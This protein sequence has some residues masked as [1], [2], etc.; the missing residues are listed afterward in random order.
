MTAANALAAADSCPGT[1]ACSGNGNCSSISQG[2]AQCS[3]YAGWDGVD[4]SIGVTQLDPSAPATATAN[5]ALASG[6][7][8]FF[9]VNTDP[10]FGDKLSITASSSNRKPLLLLARRNGRP[11]LRDFEEMDSDSWFAGS[12]TSSLTVPAVFNAQGASWYIGVYNHPLFSGG[13]AQLTLSTAYGTSVCPI[14]ATRGEC[15][16]RGVCASDKCV[17]NDG[18]SGAGCTMLLRDNPDVDMF[19]DR[20]AFPLTDGTSNG[21]VREKKY[22]V[23]S[24]TVPAGGKVSVSVT[25]LGVG[26]VEAFA[27]VGAYPKTFTDFTIRSDSAGGA[28]ALTVSNPSDSPTSAYIGLYGQVTSE[29]NMQ[30]TGTS[31]S[32]SSINSWQIGTIVAA[33]VAFVL[34]IALV[35]VIVRKNQAKE[36]LAGQDS[37]PPVAAPAV[38]TQA[39]EWQEMFDAT[40]GRNYYYNSRTG[41]TEWNKPANAV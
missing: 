34:L 4:C 38:A 3:C 26:N 5:Q 25:P 18:W 23:Y 20:D 27:T 15:S 9:Q 35:V 36:G 7:W 28:Q 40:T 30:A 8:A 31:S 6:S 37:L 32:S 10:S 22:R 14:T 13:Q 19:S 33:V 12:S 24:V 39:N 11:S 21:F 1:P 2:F 41:Q 29:Y 16:G 17:C